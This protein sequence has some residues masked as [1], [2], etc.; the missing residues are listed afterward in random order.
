MSFVPGKI[1]LGCKVMVIEC[2]SM[3]EGLKVAMPVLSGYAAKQVVT[4]YNNQQ[5]TL[6][7]FWEV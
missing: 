2:Q 3:V 7:V 6:K 5:K 1:P 4:I